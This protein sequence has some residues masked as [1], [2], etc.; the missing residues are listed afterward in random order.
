M[1]YILYCIYVLFSFNIQDDEF[2]A[3]EWERYEA[4][5]NDV[6]KQVIVYSKD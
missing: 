4:L 1:I 2:D 3:E 5:H 6:D